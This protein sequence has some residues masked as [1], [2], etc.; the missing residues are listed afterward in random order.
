[1]L[2]L[3]Q[4]LKSSIKTNKLIIKITDEDYDK[5]NKVITS[6]KNKYQI[7]L[8]S[9]KNNNKQSL[10]YI[11]KH[12]EL[13]KQIINDVLIQYNIINKYHICVFLTG[14][15][16]RNTNKLNSD[17]D[18]H[19]AY[20]QIYKEKIFKY[21]EIIYYIISSILNLN[22]SNIH[23]MLVTRLNR[24]NIDYLENILDQNEL[25]VTLQSNKENISYTYQSNTKRRIYLQYGNNNTIEEIFKYLKYEIENNNK[26]WAHVFYVFTEKEI[27][28]HNYNLLYQY[29]IS[30]LNKDRIDNRINR[31]RNKI[32]EINELLTTIDKNNI[33]EIKLV[34][35]KK[36]FALIN[37][38][39]SYKR[40]LILLSNKEWKYINYYDNQIYLNKDNNYKYIL[41]YMFAIF[42]FANPYGK[43][44]SLHSNKQIK[45]DNYNML[46]KLIKDTNKQILSTITKKEVDING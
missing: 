46:E 11:K 40:D 17:I 28:E 43:D 18:L 29:E 39:I 1:M 21:E 3:N 32:N 41:D 14:S 9:L 37:E 13:I 8:T 6:L 31:I 16:A 20:P 26:E 15:F 22:R 2:N 10:N 34:Y 5:M 44:Y 36:E 33:S 7:K 25:T 35:Q 19:F 45:I 27:F 4:E 38:Y 24:D 12:S 23:S 42:T 30:I